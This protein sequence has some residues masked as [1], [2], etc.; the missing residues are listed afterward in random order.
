MITYRNLKL[1]LKDQFENG[2]E[3]HTLF[4]ES[5]YNKLTG[6]P[7]VQYATEQEALQ[8]IETLAKNHTVRFNCYKCLYCDGY[9]ICKNYG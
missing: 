7:K 8:A 2:L 9:H 3:L 6:K 5:H 4:P 1:W